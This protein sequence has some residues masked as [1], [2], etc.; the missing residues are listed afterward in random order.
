MVSSYECGAGYSSGW[1][2]GVEADVESGVYYY[3]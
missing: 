1:V 3:E 2:V